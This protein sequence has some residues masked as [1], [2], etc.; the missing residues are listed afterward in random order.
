MTVGVID[1]NGGGLCV[2]PDDDS[3]ALAQVLVGEAD[4]VT[5]EELV[6]LRSRR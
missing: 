2:Q 4:R 1:C 5:N 6:A 3:D